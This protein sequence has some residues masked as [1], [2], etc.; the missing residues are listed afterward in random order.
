MLTK[1]IKEGEGMNLA[2][3]KR[4]DEKLRFAQNMEILEKFGL[5]GK[6]K[7]R[8]AKQKKGKV[9]VVDFV[10]KVVVKKTRTQTKKVVNG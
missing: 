1:I 10:Q 5:S 3:K 2:K 4:E 6:M 7:K 9:I 8:L